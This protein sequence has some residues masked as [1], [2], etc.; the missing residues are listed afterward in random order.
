M[1]AKAGI[2]Y[3]VSMR[4]DTRLVVKRRTGLPAGACTRTARSADPGAGNMTQVLFEPL[5]RRALWGPAPVVAARRYGA[6]P[7]GS[8]VGDGGIEARFHLHS[9]GHEGGCPFRIGRRHSACHIRA[10]RDGA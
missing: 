4:W 9:I 3:S 8:R 2:Q 10:R 5:R 6:P 1:P 7:A